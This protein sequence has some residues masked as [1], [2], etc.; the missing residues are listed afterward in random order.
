MDE[1]QP[2]TH[3]HVESQHLRAVARNIEEGHLSAHH[4]RGIADHLRRAANGLDHQNSTIAR[5]GKRLNGPKVSVEEAERLMDEAR[6]E[7]GEDPGDLSATH[8]EAIYAGV[9][10]IRSRYDELK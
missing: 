5:L 7:A 1:I 3:E 6:R 8:W 10:K 2:I 9:E 4:D